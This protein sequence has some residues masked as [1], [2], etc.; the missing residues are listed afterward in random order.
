[1][2]APGFVLLILG[3]IALVQGTFF[4]T[5]DEKKAELGPVKVIVE[6]KE[7]FHVP[8]WASVLT[9][10]AGGGLLAAGGRARRTV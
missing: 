8:V 5:R 4:V 3:L 6:E 9:V 7:S 10:L 2:R 1:V